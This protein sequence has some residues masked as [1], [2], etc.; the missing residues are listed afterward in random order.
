MIG[1]LGE[2]FRHE[3]S[4]VRRAA[5]VSDV[6]GG[7][8]FEE[9]IEVLGQLEQA[10]LDPTVV[11]LEASDETLLDRFKETRRRHP[12]APDGRV[13]GRDPCRARGARPAARAC[14]RRD[15]HQRPDRGDAAAAD[16]DRAAGAEARHAASSP[17]RSSRSASRTARHATP[18]SSSTSASCPNPH[19]REDLRPLTGR[20]A[21]VVEYVEA[22]DL[23]RR[24]LRPAVSAAR[25][26]PA[27]LRRR[28]QDAS[29]DRDRLHR[30]A[31]SLPDR[32]RPDR[33]PPRRPRRRLPAGREPR[34]RA[35]LSG[36]APPAH[37]L[38][39]GA[40]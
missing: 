31:P 23:A 1:A 16:R 13:R 30:R 39:Q 19:Y 36:T 25:L 9:L 2:L 18:T 37:R 27:R 7:E 4:G 10:G 12:L 11:F 21:T 35:G 6:R 5:I 34:R 20:D 24:V 22:G 40:S 29:D 26:P 32:R 15:G 8:Y 33:E 38:A 28:G 14:R 17:S 3:G